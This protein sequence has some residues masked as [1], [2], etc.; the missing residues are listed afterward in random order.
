GNDVK[1]TNQDVILRNMATGETSR[2]VPPLGFGFPVDWSPDGRYLTVGQLVS[3]TDQN[4]YVYDT[5][6]GETVNATP[7][8]GEIKFFPGPWSPDGSG[9]YFL[10][11]SGREY[12]GL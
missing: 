7:H 1:P 8:E 10:T 9:F 5:Q 4:I 2:P 6:T 11:D 12:T 3:N